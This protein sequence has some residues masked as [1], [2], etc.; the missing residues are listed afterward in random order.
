MEVS[1]FLLLFQHHYSAS[2]HRQPRS[3]ARELLEYVEA[4]MFLE[5]RMSEELR[6]G[7][8]A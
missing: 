2:V 6:L 3:L 5:V 7:V 1:I 8:P 4:W